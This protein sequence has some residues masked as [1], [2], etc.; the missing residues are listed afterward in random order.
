MNISVLGAGAFGTSL[1]IALSRAGKDVTLWARDAGDMAKSRENVRRLPGHALPDRLVITENME[2]FGADIVLLAVPMQTLR[3]FL[4]E[5][6]ERFSGTTLVA[7]CKGIDLETGDGPG[8]I[9][10]KSCPDA[11][12]ALLSGPSFAVDV[13]AGL[14]TA[15]TVAAKDP[16]ALQNALT[17]GNLRLY[18]STDLPGVETGGAMKNVIAI[19]CGLAIGAGLGES[20]R[21]ALMTRGFAEMNRFAIARGAESDTLQGLSGFGDLTLTC[22]SEK[23]RNF[24]YGLALGRGEVLAEGVTIEGKATAKAVSNAAEKAGIDMPITNMVV[25]VMSGHITINE[26]SELLLARP[27]K[28]E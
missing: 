18:R 11:H 23:S 4:A 5:H 2:A 6:C 21:A 24:A 7:T 8:E 10:R 20:A 3:G 13:A 22:T 1:A 17:G 15:L 27:L 14:P 19:A 25:A 12:P 28:E 9:I 26:A 16:I